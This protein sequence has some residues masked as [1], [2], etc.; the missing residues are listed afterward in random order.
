M[1]KSPIEYVYK[2]T[3][4]NVGDEVIIVDNANGCITTAHGIITRLAYNEIDLNGSYSL[5]WYDD[6]AVLR[7]LS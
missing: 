1:V 2:Y 3:D 7:V 5:E 6:A 4:L